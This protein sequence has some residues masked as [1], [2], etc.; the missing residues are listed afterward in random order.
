MPR[1][2]AH[3]ESKLRQILASRP[4]GARR[5]GWLVPAVAAVALLLTACA[6]QPPGEAGEVGDAATDPGSQAREPRAAEAPPP[7]IANPLESYG[8]KVLGEP[9][10]E[11][12]TDEDGYRYYLVEIER[13]PYHKVL[14][15]GY[16]MLP[17]GAAYELEEA[18]EDALVVRLRDSA[19]LEASRE[20]ARK[21]QPGRAEMVADLVDLEVESDD[22]LQLRKSAL[23]TRGQWR[24]GFE[25]VDMN[26]DGHLDLV[27]GPIRKGDGL[28]KIFLGDGDGGWR[29]WRETRFESQPLDYGDIAVAD[30]DGDGE[31][32]LALAIHLRG[33][34]VLRGDGEGTFTQW[35]EGLPYWYPGSGKR[36]QAYSS[37][38]VEA[39]DWN[40]DG[41]P[42]LLTLGE[43][44]RLIREPGSEAPDVSHGERGAILFLN[45]GDGRWE[46][47]D[48]G[49]RERQIFGDGLAI[50]DFDGDGR[51]DFAIAS[52]VSGATKIVKLGTE[53]GGW[54]DVAL[55]GIVRPGTYGSVHAADL[56]GDGRDELLLGF[57]AAGE[58][59]DWYTGIDL[60]E[61]EDGEWRR[62]PI[63]AEADDRTAVTALA[64]GD[65]DQ[66]G[67]IDV[68]ALTGFG[69][70]WILLGTGAKTFRREEST[71]LV[72]RE[73]S[74]QGFDVAMA[75][76]GSGGSMT[77]IMG[78]AGESGSETI[79][80]TMEAKCPSE[81]SLEAWTVAAIE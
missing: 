40:R 76:V 65:L 51:S 70:R 18:R 46:R 20:E 47:Y 73:V 54:E 22:R 31:L 10:E 57:A 71:E 62:T 74:C 58:G 8:G 26:G 75:P 80:P 64:T 34:V 63:V 56:D 14:P 33:L 72:S 12:L 45:L 77:L 66:D 17:P 27:H 32:D 59:E 52:N 25:L 4:P 2:P 19:Q 30:F 39:V 6:S 48:Q 24:Q 9:G 81:G 68:V 78:F 53:D 23:S 21:A 29:I 3:T 5:R 42:D 37:R 7:V 61:L 44:P 79:I 13:E 43:G 67:H 35:G 1:T 28:P 38:T 69:D 36:L 41:R 60:V 11:W 15:N 16:V 55:P 50:G 49:T